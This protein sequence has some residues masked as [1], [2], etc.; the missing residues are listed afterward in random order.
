MVTAAGGSCRQFN[1][2]TTGIVA[3]Y[4]CNILSVDCTITVNICCRFV[5]RDIVTACIVAP[6]QSYILTVNRPI[7]I[8]IAV[9][10]I[11]NRNVSVFGVDNE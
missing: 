5:N 8:N 11:D 2:I 1:S 9:N 10:E 6:N 7:I 3:P 4:Q